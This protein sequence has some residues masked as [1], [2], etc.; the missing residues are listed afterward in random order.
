MSAKPCAVCKSQEPMTVDRF[1]VLGTRGPRSLAKPLGLDR[2]D[3]ARHAKTCLVGER[4]EKV[5]DDLM[6]MAAR[7]GGRVVANGRMRRNQ[8]GWGAL[9]GRR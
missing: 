5:V 4:R 6:R 9:P 2:R 8:A 7:H 1:L 3:I